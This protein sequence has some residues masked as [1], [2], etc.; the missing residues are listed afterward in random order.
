MKKIQFLVTTFSNAENSWSEES[1]IGWRIGPGM[2]Q[3]SNLVWTWLARVPWELLNPKCQGR[4]IWSFPV[5]HCQKHF[6]VFGEH[7]IKHICLYLL[8]V[9]FERPTI[10]LKQNYPTFL[11][12]FFNLIFIKFRT[13]Q[14]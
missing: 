12:D 5:K 9:L 2:I 3:N 8:P 13:N 6:S 7:V 4:P 11:K 14:N 1:G 10:A